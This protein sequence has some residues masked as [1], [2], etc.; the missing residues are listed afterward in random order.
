MFYQRTAEF[1][2]H[3][4]QLKGLAPSLTYNQQEPNAAILLQ[5][6]TNSL[7]NLPL[8][9]FEP[10]LEVLVGYSSPQLQA[11][12]QKEVALDN[13]DVARQILLYLYILLLGFPIVQAVCSYHTEPELLWNMSDVTIAEFTEGDIIFN[14]AD[15]Q[16]LSDM[17]SQK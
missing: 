1:D 2:K 10:P 6:F 4:S 16:T 15:L 14:N 3:V 5:Q 8:S 9:A 17:L 13:Q 7:L 12:A 11:N